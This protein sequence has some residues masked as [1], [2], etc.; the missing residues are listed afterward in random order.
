[1]ARRMGGQDKGLLKVAGKPLIEHV[2]NSLRP[3]V[4]SL[5][6]N[7]NRNLDSYKSYGIPMVVDS[8]SGYHGPL[9]GMASCMCVVDRD[10]MVT[11]PCDSPNLPTDLVQRLYNGLIREQAEISVAHDGEYIQPVFALMQTNLLDSLLAFL[12]SGERKISKWFDRHKL[13]TVDFSDEPDAFI[14]INTPE[15]IE[16]IEAVFEKR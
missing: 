16:Q 7:I 1:M 15:D 14:N 10:Y 4:S 12:D 8:I 6:I 5:I 13:A 3:Q 2:I 11:V 9:I